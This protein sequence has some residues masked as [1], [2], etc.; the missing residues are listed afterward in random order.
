MAWVVPA[1]VYIQRECQTKKR[2]PVMR[3]VGHTSQS[4]DATTQHSL[5]CHLQ[6]VSEAVAAKVVGTRRAQ[7]HDRYLKYWAKKV[8]AR[9]PV[10][11]CTFVSV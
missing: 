6:Y 3:W 9:L 5:S 4:S 8:R 2:P 1:R 10:L 11:L 7:V